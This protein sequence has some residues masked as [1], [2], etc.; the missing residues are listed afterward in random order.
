MTKFKEIA[1]GKL[2]K[3]FA[4]SDGYILRV[5]KSTYAEKK[6]KPYLHHNQL[7]VKINNKDLLLGQLIAKHFVK[8]WYSGCCIF[9]KDS[10]KQNCCA[11]NLI[12]G[13][14]EEHGKNT[15][16]KADNGEV[17]DTDMNRTILERYADTYGIK[18]NES[19]FD[20]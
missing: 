4:C 20:Y 9:Y 18:Y 6:V 14:Y 10:N 2:F 11:D 16:I 13:S 17:Y 8:G 3:Y 1:E 19:I 15:G 7:T 5:T 12:I